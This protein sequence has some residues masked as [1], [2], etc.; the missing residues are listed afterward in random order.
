[1]NSSS[2][3]S[4]VTQP[5]GYPFAVASHSLPVPVTVVVNVAAGASFPIWSTATISTVTTAF[6]LAPGAT[7]RSSCVVSHADHA[8]AP[9]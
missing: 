4:A 1:M 6:A 3:T 2:A 8:P 5:E 7:T 9:I